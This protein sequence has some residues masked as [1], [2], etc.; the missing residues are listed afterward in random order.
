[1]Q[2]DFRELIGY[3][4]AWQRLQ[5]VAA[6]QRLP[7]SLLIVGR[8]GMGKRAFANGIIAYERCATHTA[9]GHCGPCRELLNGLDEDVLWLDG[10]ESLKVQD[11]DD[12]QSFLQV[13]PI[14]GH[15]TRVVVIV[16]AERLM[17]QAANRLLKTLEEPMAA[18]RIILTTA[19]PE[20]LLPTILSRL[21]VWRLA[22]PQ[23]E[24]VSQWLQQRT[25]L[26]AKDCS[27]LS[28]LAGYAP[29]KALQLAADQG[30]GWRE[31]WQSIALLLTAHDI[32]KILDNAALIVQQ[33]KTPLLDVIDKAELVLNHYYRQNFGLSSEFQPLLEGVNQ[34]RLA[35]SPQSVRAR[36]KLL[37]ELREFV[38]QKRVAINALMATEALGLVAR[39]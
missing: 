35:L 20:K 7:Q 10:A 25:G 31:S 2:A 29:G 14:E 21:V 19:R 34:A 22:L 4:A 9:C 32:D 23:P 33:N 28:S 15:A 12:L 5:L 38:S 24:V 8:E 1:M 39:S 27:W 36:R 17:D 37:H 30:Q 13:M 3:E 16:D 26:P 11:M 6:Q 18:A